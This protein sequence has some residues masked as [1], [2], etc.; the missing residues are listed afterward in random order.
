MPGLKFDF[1][2]PSGYEDDSKK[3]ATKR[4]LAELMLSKGL[5]PENMQSW[6]QVLAHIGQAYAG[7][8]LGDK[9]DQI[10]TE[11]D[12]KKIADYM[13]AT[14]GFKADEGTLS[15]KDLRTKYA[16]NPF[17]ESLMKPHDE[18]YGAGLRGREE[19]RKFGDRVGPTKDFVGQREFDPNASV[20]PTANGYG[21]NPV[22]LASS[23]MSQG[24]SPSG[25]A[26]IP[27]ALTMPDPNG[28]APAASPMAAPP[29]A[30]PSDP[31]G[32][33]PTPNDYAGAISRVESH[34]RDFN[35]HGQPVTSSAGAKYAMQ[36]MSTTAHKP[37]YGVDPVHNESADEYNRVGRAYAEAMR[38]KFGDAGGAAAYNGGPGRFEQRGRDISRMPPETQAYVPK[39]MNQLH[40]SR[41][42]DGMTLDGQPFWNVN[43]RAFDNP[44][45]K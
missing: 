36:V 28:V 9:A 41:P 44:E 37:G 20:I 17:T 39:V 24:L 11:T 26:T 14:Q 27:A 45:G 3:A 21:V 29:A 8:R 35:N 30:P 12:K 10:D 16:G 31:L 7:K 1:K 42:P 13:A 15:E 19:Y 4:K 33:L 5:A 43:G 40:S 38:L 2:L 23:L 22:K 6:T 18:A 25:G 32:P 34:N